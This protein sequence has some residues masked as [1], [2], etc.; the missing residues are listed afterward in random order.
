MALAGLEVVQRL[1]PAASRQ[2]HNDVAGFIY[3][4]LGVIYAVL[5]A[6]V[7]IAVWEEYDAASVTVEQEA[8][9]VAEIFWLAHRL[10]EPEGPHIQELARSYAEEVVEHE[11][12]LMEQGKLP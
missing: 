12:P 5:I 11:W 7:V 3:A 1:V 4:A 10:P 9:A 2:R 8:N 6:L